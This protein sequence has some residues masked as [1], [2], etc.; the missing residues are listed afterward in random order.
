MP[1]APYAGGERPAGSNKEGPP[2]A[3]LFVSYS[4]LLVSFFSMWLALIYQ[5]VYHLP[6]HYTDVDL[7]DSFCPFGNVLSSKVF[8]DRETNT[9]RCFGNY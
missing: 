6:N 8:M 5:Q 4:H 9:S 3:N 2:G 1:P 7:Y